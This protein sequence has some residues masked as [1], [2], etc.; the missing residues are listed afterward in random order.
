MYATSD[1]FKLNKKK[2]FVGHTI[3]GYACQIGVSRDNK[4]VTSGDG[5]G[6][7]WLWDWKSTKVIRV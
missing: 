3:A 1:R 5:D 2:H 4:Y 7:L 6:R